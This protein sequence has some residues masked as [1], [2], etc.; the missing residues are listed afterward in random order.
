MGVIVVGIAKLCH[1]TIINACHHTINIANCNGDCNS[2]ITL[3][4]LQIAMGYIYEI[5]V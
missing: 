5:I 2:E 3:S 4:V 1:H